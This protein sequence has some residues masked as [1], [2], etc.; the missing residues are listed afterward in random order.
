MQAK[1][2]ADVVASSNLSDFAR[3]DAS[4]YSIAAHEPRA[5]VHRM[6]L[7][8]SFDVAAADAELVRGSVD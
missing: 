8:G 5:E 3:D 7:F 1:H 6:R 4:S 2:Q